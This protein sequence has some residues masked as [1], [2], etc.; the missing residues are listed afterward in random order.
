[1]VPKTLYPVLSNQNENAHIF[2]VEGLVTSL[3]LCGTLDDQWRSIDAHLIRSNWQMVTRIEILEGPK[4]L[5]L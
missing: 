3:A 2:Q 5:V 4:S 1:M